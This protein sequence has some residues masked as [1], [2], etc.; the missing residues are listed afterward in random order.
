MLFFFLLICNPLLLFLFFVSLFCQLL[1]CA[2]FII[3]LRCCLI[4]ETV[5]QLLKTGWL[6]FIVRL[7]HS[8][9]CFHP[10]YFSAKHTSD[11]HFFTTASEEEKI[12]VI[13]SDW[14][15]RANIHGHALMTACSILLHL[16]GRSQVKRKIAALLERQG[17][18]DCVQIEPG[19][20]N[21]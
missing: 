10:E 3:S 2:C 14:R 21:R 19:N 9:F 16:N 5:M 13:L 12:T 20:F 11:S 1:M 18:Y 15:K 4:L 7:F 6:L 8:P 17:H